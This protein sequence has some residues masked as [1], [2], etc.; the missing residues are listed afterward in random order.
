MQSR[1]PTC[2]SLGNHL[3]SPSFTR[4]SRNKVHAMVSIAPVSTTHA[5]SYHVL[6][7]CACVRAC[8]PLHLA[9]HFLMAHIYNRKR[10]LSSSVRGSSKIDLGVSIQTR[11]VPSILYEGHTFY[12]SSS[13][14]IQSFTQSNPQIPIELS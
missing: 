3:L 13:I 8:V 12:L 5:L 1:P 10:G 6:E 4:R 7:K 14:A 11:L 2:L 9:F